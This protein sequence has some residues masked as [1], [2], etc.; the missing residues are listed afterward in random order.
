M[1]SMESEQTLCAWCDRPL[2]R[3][4]EVYFYGEYICIE[5]Y[6]INQKIKRETFKLWKG[7]KKNAHK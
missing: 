3:K 2:E 1:N 6:R 5:C 4:K 7:V